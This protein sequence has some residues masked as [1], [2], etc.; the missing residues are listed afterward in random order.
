MLYLFFKFQVINMATFLV[1]IDERT[2]LG[3]AILELLRSTAKESKAIEL[4]DNTEAK[5]NY[6][7]DFVNMV[8]EAVASKNRIRID[9]KNL[10]EIIN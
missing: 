4:I 8:L 6:N 5:D 10:W 1:K 2:R 7:E 9:P 3:K